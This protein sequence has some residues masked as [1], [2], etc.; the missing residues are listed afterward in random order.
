[1][2][3]QRQGGRAV[4]LCRPERLPETRCMASGGSRC[5][6]ELVLGGSIV[7]CL[8]LADIP[9]TPASYATPATG[10]STAATC[11]AT[12]ATGY[13]TAAACCA[14]LATNYSTIAT[15]CVTLATGYST[16]PTSYATL[17]ATSSTTPTSGPT[18]GQADSPIAAAPSLH[19]SNLV[20]NIDH[21]PSSL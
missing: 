6:L 21:L 18:P 17:P 1:M 8:P 14:T 16:V 11:C 3:A 19:R 20:R 5:R 4:H 13:S 2:S 15:C 9:I 7:S 12:L 10:Y